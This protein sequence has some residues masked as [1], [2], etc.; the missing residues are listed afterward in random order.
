MDTRCL[1]D[2]LYMIRHIFTN[3]N[4]SIKLINVLNALSKGC[5]K[6][7]TRLNEVD[8]RGRHAALL[9]Y[10]IARPVTAHAKA[11]SSKILA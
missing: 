3:R 10:V 9:Y 7:G 2:F 1:A 11:S 4:P 5:D 6:D 8:S